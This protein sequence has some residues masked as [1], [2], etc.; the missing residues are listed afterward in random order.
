ML[1]HWP[2]EDFGRND[3]SECHISSYRKLFKQNV[4]EY[5]RKQTSGSVDKETQGR[6][7]NIAKI[8]RPH[9]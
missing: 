4:E 7:L 2:M 6:H 5:V 3:T 1:C 8:S 9:M